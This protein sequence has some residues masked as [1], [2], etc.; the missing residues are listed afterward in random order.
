MIAKKFR[1]KP[2]VIEA[3]LQDNSPESFNQIYDWNNAVKCNPVEDGNT[4][5]EIPTLEGT[6]I[7]KHGD[8]VIKG[9]KGEIY[10]CKADIFEATYEEEIV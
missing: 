6:M 2:V 5:V 3:V 4:E 7:A 1:K 8:W 10:P 9:V